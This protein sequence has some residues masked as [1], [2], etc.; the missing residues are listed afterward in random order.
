MIKIKRI[1][2]DFSVCQLEDYS[3]VNYDSLYYFI[4]K[5]GTEKSLV[6]LTSDVPS[7]TIKREDGWK[8]M[9]I[10]GTLDFSLIGILSKIADILAKNHISIFVVSTYDTDYLL[11]KEE[12]FERA[13]DLLKN[14]GYEI[15]D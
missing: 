15:I 4:E 5:T 6:C 13:L 14:E 1:Q 10:Q 11:V 7:N 9:Y 12:N 8:A 2:Y 3:L